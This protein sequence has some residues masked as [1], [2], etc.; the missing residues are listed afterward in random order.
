MPVPLE[1]NDDPKNDYEQLLNIKLEA[2]GRHSP[3]Y[4]DTF[5]EEYVTYPQM[6][7]FGCSEIYLINLERRTERKKLMEMN[8]KELGMDVKLFKAVDGR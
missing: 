7:K 5:L 1:D 3:L 4:I 2:I 6:W 8:F